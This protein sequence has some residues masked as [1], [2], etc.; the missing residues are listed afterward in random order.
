M[1]AKAN[2]V[3]GKPNTVVGKPNTVVGK[4]NTVVGKPNRWSDTRTLLGHITDSS[5]QVSGTLGQ[6][7]E[8]RL[9]KNRTHKTC[10]TPP[11]VNMQYRFDW[12]LQSLYNVFV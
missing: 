9:S 11:W 1:V 8:T 5:G 3:V 4:P 2:T 10:E 12:A 7:T 6:G